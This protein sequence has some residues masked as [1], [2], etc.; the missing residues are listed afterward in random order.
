MR[1]WAGINIHHFVFFFF[2]GSSSMETHSRDGTIP[3]TWFYAS[4][5][6]LIMCPE[7]WVFTFP[8]DHCS[9]LTSGKQDLL[10][11]LAL[12]VDTLPRWK[13]FLFTWHALSKQVEN[14]VR[15]RFRD[16]IYLFIFP[17][18]ACGELKLITRRL[19]AFLKL[20]QSFTRKQTCLSIGNARCFFIFIFF[21]H[22]PQHTSCT[23]GMVSNKIDNVISELY[24]RTFHTIKP[25][26]GHYN[27]T[28]AHLFQVSLRS[29]NLPFLI[30]L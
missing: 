5:H 25:V 24:A 17:S 21:I 7:P 19:E 12:Q 16:F 30:L 22:S 28:Q 10:E 13:N 6:L 2:F 18:A 11:I 8:R 9:S 1:V 15:Y 4:F 3:G 23:R 26:I 29:L 14:A 20:F 27:H